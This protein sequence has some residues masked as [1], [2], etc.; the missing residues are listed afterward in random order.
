MMKFFYY[1]QK[2]SIRKF[3]SQNFSGK[4]LLNFFF[5]NE[6]FFRMIRLGNFF[7]S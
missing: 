6:K 1:S 5:C 2:S 7:G 4:F 3:F